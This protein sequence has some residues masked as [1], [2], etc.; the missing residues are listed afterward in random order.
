MKLLL[1]RAARPHRVSKSEHLLRQFR[2]GQR[3]GAPASVPA[4][5]IVEPDTFAVELKGYFALRSVP[6]LRYDGVD[7]P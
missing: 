6:V 3:S 1:G 5:C 7:L 2:L 4:R